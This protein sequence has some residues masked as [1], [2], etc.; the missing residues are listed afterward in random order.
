MQCNVRQ[1]GNFNL[2][3]VFSRGANVNQIPISAPIM[4]I[5]PCN[6]AGIN[7]IPT[8]SWTMDK[9]RCQMNKDNW[10]DNKCQ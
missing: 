3:S 6:Q 9:E 8:S 1:K 5:S 10:V 4:K 2:N 7:I